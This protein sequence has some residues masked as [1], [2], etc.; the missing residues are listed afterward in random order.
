MI[1]RYISILKKHE[2]PVRFVLARLLVLSG[3]CRFFTIPQNGYRIRFH[4]AN[5]PTNLWI[6]PCNREDALSFFNA[7]LK[8]GD[9]VID[10]GANIGDT[11]LT[12]SVRVGPTG[13][14]TGIEAHPRTFSFLAENIALNEATNVT[15]IHSAAGD[16][17]GTVNFSDSRYDDM[18]QVN[19]GDLEVPV[20][21]LDDLIE[22]PDSIALLKIDVE[23]YELPVFR[24][25][26]RILSQAE[27]IYFEAGETMC[28]DFGYEVDDLLQAAT[29]N[30]FELY[31][32][33]L[34][35]VLT[36]IKSGQSFIPYRNIV[37]CRD[38][39]VLFQRTGWS[40]TDLPKSLNKF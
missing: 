12:S 7:Y 36:T 19:H 32:H 14:V 25:A 9:R 16:Q 3:L 31:V 13:H 29:D 4:P 1:N 30:G 33:E 27:C 23:G 37:G 10:V 38:S 22:S 21:P 35:T 2:H 8:S 15:L 26:R 24:G 34:G 11:V 18:N 28:R 6:N 5:L 40:L 39:R 17:K 20:R